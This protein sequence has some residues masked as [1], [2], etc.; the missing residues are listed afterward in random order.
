[1]FAQGAYATELTVVS[2]VVRGREGRVLQSG[3]D[4]I[5]ARQGV[6][7]ELAAVGDGAP[8]DVLDFVDVRPNGEQRSREDRAGVDAFVDDVQGDAGE[9]VAVA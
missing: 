7:D 6:G 9:V 8:P 1:V 5:E 3:R 4:L 2:A